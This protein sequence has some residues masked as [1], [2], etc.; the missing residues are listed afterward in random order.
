VV[1]GRVQS[2]K[3]ASVEKVYMFPSGSNAGKLIDV[4]KANQSFVINTM[5]LNKNDR[6]RFSTIRSNGSMARSNMHINIQK[7]SIK[8][9]FNSDI[10][11]LIINE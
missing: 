9:P 5:F 8:K 10:P 11:D 2:S 6:L 3:G 4:D 7:N 1:R